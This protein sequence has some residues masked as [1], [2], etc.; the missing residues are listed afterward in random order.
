MGSLFLTSKMAETGLIF[1]SGIKHGLLFWCLNLVLMA[2]TGLIFASLAYFS[3][4]EMKRYPKITTSVT[5][6]AMLISSLFIADHSKMQHSVYLSS[7]F[8]QLFRVVVK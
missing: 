4:L 5:L 6:S 2:E 7:Y 8:V 1:A 3:A